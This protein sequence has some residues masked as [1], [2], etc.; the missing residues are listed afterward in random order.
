MNLSWVH[1][2]LKFDHF[3]TGGKT[4]KV[5]ADLE[6]QSLASQ[7]A[8]SQN[9]LGTVRRTHFDSSAIRRM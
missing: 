5:R 4:Y 3:H 7:L 1:W 8:P 9:A 6:Q 2:S